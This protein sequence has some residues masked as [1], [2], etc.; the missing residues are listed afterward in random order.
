MCKCFSYCPINSDFQ[1]TG[2]G[3]ERL[4]AI[5]PGWLQNIGHSL[6]LDCNNTRSSVDSS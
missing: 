5:L 1:S 6:A 4:G 3:L 2:D